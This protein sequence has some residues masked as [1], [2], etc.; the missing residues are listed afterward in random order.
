MVSAQ[1]SFF[2][3][4]SWVRVLLF[5]CS[6]PGSSLPLCSVGSGLG[7]A[8]ACTNRSLC[9][10]PG[11]LPSSCPGCHD[12]WVGG[13]Q[14]VSCLLKALHKAAQES[15]ATVIAL[16]NLLGYSQVGRHDLEPEIRFST[17]PSSE[18][19]TSRLLPARISGRRAQGAMNSYYSCAVRSGSGAEFSQW[20]HRPLT[21]AS[22]SVYW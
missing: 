18:W 14:C 8:C 11:F 2:P 15:L 10:S 22:C 5:S 21:L 9:F 4:S 20:E 17:L 13:F 6:G 12:L 19:V 3:P 16:G 7:C 1:V